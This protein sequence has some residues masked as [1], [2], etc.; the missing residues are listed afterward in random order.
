MLYRDKRP[1]LV[2]L[3]PSFA[4]MVIFLYYPFV[5]NIYNSLFDIKGMIGR[6]EAFLGLQNYVTFFTRDP[7]AMTALKNS[8]MLMPLT[9]VFQVG[10]AIVLALLVDNIKRGQQFFRVVFFFPI[11]I[12]ATAIGLMFSLFYNYDGGMLNQILRMLGQEKVLWLSKQRAYTMVIIPV[13]WQYVGFYFVIVLT[14]LAAVPDEI[15]ESASIDGASGLQ[16]VWYITL[17][18]IKD[19][20][21]TCTTLAITGAV[22]VFDLP[23]VIAK[24]GAPNGLTH[25]LG[26]YMHQQAFVAQNVDYG[27]AISIVIVVIG[28]VVAQGVGKALKP[29]RDLEGGQ[30]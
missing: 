12:S 5:M 17:P 14:G 10:T 22:K 16:K 27:S 30:I 2:L 1:L 8:L 19:V 7:V 4:L 3:V 24:F 26:T 13:L 29:R 9:V 25:F 20:L 15:N 21:I 28:V 23:A 18:M 6:P 11:V